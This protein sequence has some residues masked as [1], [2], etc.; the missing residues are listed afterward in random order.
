M[1]RFLCFSLVLG[2]AVALGW[3][4]LQT[5]EE[6]PAHA[7]GGGGQ[8]QGAG[9]SGN[10]DV[11]G[12]NTI[13]LSDAIYLLAH[14]FQG[15]PAPALCPGGSCTVCDDQGPGWRTYTGHRG[16]LCPCLYR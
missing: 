11:N 12:D 5:F 7:D 13:D 3:F 4:F 9:V 15:G 16:S 8:G 1:K 10:G 2:A 6:G 14:L